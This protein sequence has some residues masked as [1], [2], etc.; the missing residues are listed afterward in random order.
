M[1]Q[2]QRFRVLV[3]RPKP[4]GELLCRHLQAAGYDTVYLPAQEIRPLADTLALRA[5]IAAL[6]QYDWA[7]FVSRSAVRTSVHL[8]HSAW[9]KLP[10]ELRF[11]AVGEGTAEALREAG[12]PPALYPSDSWTSE[13]LLALPELKQVK[14]QRIALF[15]GEGGRALLADSLQERGAQVTRFVS[16]QRFLPQEDRTPTQA[17]LDQGQ[18]EAVVV[19]SAEGLSNLQKMFSSET[20][21]RLKK[22]PLVLVSERIMIQAKEK[23][24]ERCF[25]AKSA[26]HE[27][28]L[29]ALNSIR[30]K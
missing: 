3:T 17:L 30:I 18:I 14:E 24:F 16:Y 2:P 13:G 11:A 29:Q 7:I 22:I 21:G 5:Q 4:E 8:I 10:R 9:S 6:D 1:S 12:L 25:L 23:G 26:S 19:T 15:C 28:I 27:G 20:G